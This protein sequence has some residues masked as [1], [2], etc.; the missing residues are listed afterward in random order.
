M[1]ATKTDALFSIMCILLKRHVELDKAQKHI[2][3]LER[4]RKE[5]VTELHHQL[6]QCTDVEL[7]EYISR[8]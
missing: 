6:L 1:P 2:H 7:A 5:E 8:L 4:K 3:A